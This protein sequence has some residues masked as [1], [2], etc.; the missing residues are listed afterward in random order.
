MR[1]FLP[2][3]FACHLVATL[4]MAL[5]FPGFAQNSPDTRLP[6]NERAYIASRVYASLANFAHAQDLRQADLDATYRSYLERA[7]AAEDRF[8]FSRAS[9]E[10]LCVLF[11]NLAK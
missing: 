2:R 10:L 3:G 8:T 11:G 9:M 6:L 7:L 5:Y 4:S 1:R